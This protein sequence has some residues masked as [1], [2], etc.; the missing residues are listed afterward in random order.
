MSTKIE[1]ILNKCT[2]LH[3]NHRI[4]VLKYM[5]KYMIKYIWV[6]WNDFKK[7]SDELVPRHIFLYHFS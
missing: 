2:Y 7:G 4:L 5:I 3:K 1:D 6:S